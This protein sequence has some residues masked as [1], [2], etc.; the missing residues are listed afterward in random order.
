MK[1]KTKKKHF[2]HNTNNNDNESKT[3]VQLC[4]FEEKIEKRNKNK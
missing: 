2:Q 3:T 4:V 1:E